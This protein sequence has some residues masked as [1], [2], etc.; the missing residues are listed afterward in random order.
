[1]IRFLNGN[2]IYA[3]EFKKPFEEGGIYGHVD[4]P[5]LKKGKNGGAFWSAYV[6]CPKNITDFSDENYFD[7]KPLNY[8]TL[9]RFRPLLLQSNSCH[10]FTSSC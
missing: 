2:E 5:R 3:D 1:M 4:L 6:P 8:F 7:G 9:L 10:I